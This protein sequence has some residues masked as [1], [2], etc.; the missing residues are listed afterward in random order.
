MKKYLLTLLLLSFSIILIGCKKRIDTV[1]YYG[2]YCILDF[3]SDGFLSDITGKRCFLIREYDE[4][5][6]FFNEYNLRFYDVEKAENKFNED[7]FINHALIIYCSEY[8]CGT[9]YKIFR[10]S[11]KILIYQYSLIY[12]GS[13]E[14]GDDDE[15]QIYRVFEVKKNDIK[16]IVE[17]ENV[18]V[19]RY[20]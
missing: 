7:Y 5:N 8:G 19:Y 12:C 18:V 11:K 15:V 1:E 4:M 16:K 10:K 6:L 20:E 17:V 3:K 9:Y 13:E 14:Y 2:H